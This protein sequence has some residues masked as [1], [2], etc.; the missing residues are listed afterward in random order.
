MPTRRAY[1]CGVCGL[2]F[3]FLVKSNPRVD[4]RFFG[5]SNPWVDVRFFVKSNPWVWWR[6]PFHLLIFVSHFF[7]FLLILS[8]LP[9]S[10]CM[11]LRFR[12][13]IQSGIKNRRTKS[14]P[15]AP[16]TSSM[17]TGS[18]FYFVWVGSEE[19]GA[20]LTA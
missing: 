7:S 20:S 17:A 13:G 18:L 3:D 15:P 9:R 10:V 14:S 1:G 11:I 8:L 19:A 16:R 12:P 6:Y 4:V 5:K 2:F